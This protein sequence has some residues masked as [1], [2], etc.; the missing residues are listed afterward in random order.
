MVKKRGFT[1]IELLVAVSIV[2]VLAIVG[3]AIYVKF[4]QNARDTRRQAD[5]KAIQS[6]LEQY[7][8]DQFYYPCSISFGSALTSSNGNCKG[9][10][11]STVKTYLNL[12][13]TEQLSSR[14]PYSYAAFASSAGGDCDNDTTKC[15]FYCLWASTEIISNSATG[16]SAPAANPTNYTY[17]VIPQ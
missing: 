13:P 14:S 5:L 12:V 9:S 16:C 2:A 6:A 8:A 7:F 3:I 15:S 1:L 11:P 17:V 4:I 10:A